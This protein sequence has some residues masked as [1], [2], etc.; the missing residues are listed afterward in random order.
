MVKNEP[1][2]AGDVGSIPGSSAKSQMQLSTHT[3]KRTQCLLFWR[4]PLRLKILHGFK[5]SEF[6]MVSFTPLYWFL[7]VCF[8]FYVF[9]EFINLLQYCFCF[10]FW[11][12]GSKTY[13]VLAPQLSWQPTFLF[14]GRDTTNLD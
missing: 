10:M 11:F 13:R 9:I 2:N 12:L 1:A 3:H 5:S 6:P 8:V 4:A 7:F 14:Q